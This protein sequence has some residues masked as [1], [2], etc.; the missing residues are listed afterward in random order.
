MRDGVPPSGRDH[1]QSLLSF[2]LLATI[3]P[4]S[5][6]ARQQTLDLC[7]PS[8]IA[9][10]TLVATSQTLMPEVF[11]SLL[12]L[13][14]RRMGFLLNVGSAVL[15]RA[16]EA[17]VRISPSCPP[18]FPTSSHI[19]LTPSSLSPGKVINFTDSPPPSSSSSLSSM[20]S[21]FNLSTS[22]PLLL[23]PSAG[24]YALSSLPPSIPSSSSS[25]T[26]YPP[27]LAILLRD[28]EGASKILMTF[29]SPPEASLCL[30]K[31]NGARATTS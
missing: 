20:S 21:S 5:L 31:S 2:P 14:E 11:S 24:T 4:E 3:V 17:K 19:V 30:G 18:I 13:A 7:P 28:E 27:S 16:F 9:V 15:Q 1:R 23:N 25:L 29:S 12:L 26:S 8:K 22:P 10:Q 6:N